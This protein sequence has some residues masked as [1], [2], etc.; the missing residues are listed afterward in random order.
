[1]RNTQDIHT[2]IYNQLVNQFNQ[3]KMNY[4]K[5]LNVRV[6]FH[7]GLN[8]PNNINKAYQDMAYLYHMFKLAN[9]GVIGCQFVLEHSTTK[10]LHVH[11][12]F[13]INGQQHQKYYPFYLWLNDFWSKATGDLGYTV[14][15]NNS[16]QYK[17]SVVGEVK[18]YQDDSFDKGMLHLIRYFSKQDQK[19]IIPDFYRCFTSQVLQ[20]THRGRPRNNVPNLLLNY[21][22][23][24]VTI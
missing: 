20:K 15:C 2:Q 18:G 23:S 16:N 1:M 8:Q 22:E 21:D 13:F 6:D 10:L 7:Y 14:D 3:L 11:A 12:I 5:L 9:S 17:Y 4:S 19:T 24:N